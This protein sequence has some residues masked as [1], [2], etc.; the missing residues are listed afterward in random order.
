VQRVANDLGGIITEMNAAVAGF[1]EVESGMAA[2][3]TGVA[4]I[5]GAVRQVADGARQTTASVSE[6]SRVASE[7]SHSVA[8]LQDAVE[9]FR[10]VEEVP[11]TNASLVYAHSLPTNRASLHSAEKP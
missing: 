1:S 5:E 7:L 6:F 9:R 10:L 8:V 11:S 2:Q 3:A 4:Q